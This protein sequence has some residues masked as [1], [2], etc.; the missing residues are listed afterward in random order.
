MLNIGSNR[1]H[2][3]GDQCWLTI[4]YVIFLLLIMEHV[5]EHFENFENFK[6]C[7]VNIMKTF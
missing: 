5:E 2:L 7:H 4:F 3:G 6:K 1:A